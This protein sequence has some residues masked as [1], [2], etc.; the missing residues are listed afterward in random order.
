MGY[1]AGSV[2]DVI[3]IETPSNLTSSEFVQN[4]YNENIDYNTN[5]KVNFNLLSKSFLWDS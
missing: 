3:D 5:H 1:P 4:I 2:K